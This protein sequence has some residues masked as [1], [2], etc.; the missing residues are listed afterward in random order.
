MN[1][2]DIELDPTRTYTNE[3]IVEM[4]ASLYEGQSEAILIQWQGLKYRVIAGN[5]RVLAG[6]LI[7]RGFN[8]DGKYF[9]P[10]LNYMMKIRVS[11]TPQ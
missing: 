3:K 9:S 11:E 4:A 5:L 2:F 8:Y 10:K 1:P 6:R 7:R